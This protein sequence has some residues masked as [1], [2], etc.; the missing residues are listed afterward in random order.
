MWRGAGAAWRH[1]GGQELAPAGKEDSS[2]F[3]GTQGFVSCRSV[4]FNFSTI[5]N[6]GGEAWSPG[7]LLPLP[8]VP[9]LG[10]LFHSPWVQLNR[11]E[12]AEGRPKLG[13]G[14]SERLM[15]SA[16]GPVLVLGLVSACLKCCC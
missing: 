3:C 6:G 5:K 13:E 15:L 9:A 14:P 2:V 16:Q 4:G 10:S 8:W 12:E 7:M 11:W 1:C